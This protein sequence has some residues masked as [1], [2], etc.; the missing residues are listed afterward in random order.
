M[1][2]LFF[3]N[4]LQIKTVHLIFCHF[5]QNSWS[6]SISIAT[7][8]LSAEELLDEDELDDDDDDDDQEDDNDDEPPEEYRCDPEV[9]VSMEELRELF[10][11]PDDEES[12]GSESIATGTESQR[13]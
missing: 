4:L 10:D 5:Y 8:I 7:D 13:S 3:P 9:E 11:F 12:D 1:K 6:Q 2:I